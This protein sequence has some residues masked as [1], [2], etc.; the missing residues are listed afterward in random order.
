M[1]PG[2]SREPSCGREIRGVDVTAVYD[3]WERGPAPAESRLVDLAAHVG[4]G[5]EKEGA[6]DADHQV[7]GAL[8]AQL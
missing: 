3:D 6:V 8:A 4:H 7:L 2:H 5:G 1:L